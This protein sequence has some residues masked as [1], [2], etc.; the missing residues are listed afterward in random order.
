MGDRPTKKRKYVRITDGKGLRRK[1][2]N[3]WRSTY[4][5]RWARIA[6]GTPAKKM[7]KLRYCD[8]ISINPAAGLTAS[9]YFRANGMFDPDRTGAG[10]QPLYY[11]QLITMYD[12]YTVHGGF[13]KMTYVHAG[14][15]AQ[16][17]GAFG[18]FLDDNA[19]QSYASATAI[20]EGGQKGGTVWT[21]TAGNSS[22][23]NSTGKSASPWV[24]LSFDAKKFFGVKSLDGAQFRTGFGSSP[25]EDANYCCYYGAIGGNDPPIAYFIIEVEY[26]AIFT[27]KS[28]TAQ[29]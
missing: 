1:T 28:Y 6:V 15:A 17:P 9:H 29:S 22:G 23:G 21:T 5:A 24:K 8:T 2:Y 11:D 3:R 13:L 12:H 7:V 14:S 10:H 16:V 19:T 25:T 4:K 18:I 20:I 27:E 26:N